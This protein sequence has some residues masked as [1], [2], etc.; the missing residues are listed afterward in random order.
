M[1]YFKVQEVVS[2]RAYKERGER[3]I[4]M[5][6]NRILTFLDNLREALGQPITCNTW[7]VGG[8]CQWRGI[9]TS[10]S[11]WFSQYSQHSFGRAIDCKIK[12]ISAE[13]ARQWVIKNRDLDWV[14]PITFLEAGESV[15][16]LHCDVRCGT[17]GDLWVWNKDTGKTEVYKRS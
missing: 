13:E 2:E 8:D 6:D 4:T 17:G 12:G 15:T 11:P 7:H 5:L 9:R 16:W 14:K 3:A 10:E 1:K